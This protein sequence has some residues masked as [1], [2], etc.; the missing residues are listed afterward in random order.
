ME[1][2]RLIHELN[3]SYQIQI[4]HIELHRDLIGKVYFVQTAEKKYMFKIY[5]S[6]KSED[7]LQSVGILDYL[8]ANSYPA[9][10]VV[11]TARNDSHIILSGDEGC[12]TGIL[13]DYIEGAVPDGKLEAESIG[14]Q[15]GE[16][17]NLM[18]SYPHKL[19]HRTKTD[20]IDDY[21]TIMRQ[22]DFAPAK[23]L[24]LQQYGD[25]LW[26]RITKLPKSFCHGDLHTGNMIRNQSGEYVLFDFDDA[27][28]DYPGMDAAYMSD[29][30]HFNQFH[31]LMYDHTLALYERFYSGYS[32]VRTLSSSEFHAI[33]DF[34]AV[35]HF[36]IV[37]RIVRCQGLQSICIEFCEEQH[38]WLMRWREQC[39]EKQR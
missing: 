3:R 27:S 28:G 22:M 37:S 11:R 32:K 35:R 14:K 12:C 29:D 13:Y 20:Y 31:E 17:H 8:K 5:R 2:D 25:E 19:I 33:F 15:I 6:F 30:T 4:E 21:L 18:E 34:I 36:Q 9:V 23:I 39:M 38:D 1:H 24:E 26:E 10:S 16:L 7:A